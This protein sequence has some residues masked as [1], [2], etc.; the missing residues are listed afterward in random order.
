M[1]CNDLYNVNHRIDKFGMGI[2]QFQQTLIILRSIKCY[3]QMIQGAGAG[4]PHKPE[5]IRVA[6]EI[7]SYMFSIIGV[8]RDFGY[9]EQAVTTH[10][11]TV[12]AYWKA[13]LRPVGRHI[14]HA[15]RIEC[16]EHIVQDSW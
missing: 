13:T 5:T 6:I 4:M 2:E 3:A 8:G 11:F 9:L 14:I 7:G 1:A 12:Q 16:G 10:D 15:G